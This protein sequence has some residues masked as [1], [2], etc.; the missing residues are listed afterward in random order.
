MFLNIN[1]VYGYKSPIFL[2]DVDT[3]NLI[4]FKENYSGKKTMNNLLV[5]C[6]MIIKL[7]HCMQC[8]Q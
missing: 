4:V 8:F 1:G 3:E 5:T 2:E 6:I 7:I